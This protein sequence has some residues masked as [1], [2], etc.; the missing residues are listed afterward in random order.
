VNSMAASHVQAAPT[1]DNPGKILGIKI[2]LHYSWFII[3]ILVVFS[4]SGQFRTTN[5]RWGDG[6]IYAM[7][8]ATALLFFVSLLLHELAHS[9]VATRRAR[10]GQVVA[11]GFIAFG[12]FPVL[13]R[14]RH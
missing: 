6:I 7:S 10:A 2:G 11:F 13:R 4:L 14:R 5:P 9:Y 1:N 12:I 8:I 3:A